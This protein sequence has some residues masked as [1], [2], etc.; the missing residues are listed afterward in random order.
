MERGLIK[1][2]AML[3]RK[4]FIDFESLQESMTRLMNPRNDIQVVLVP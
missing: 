2:E 1:T 3:S 4:S